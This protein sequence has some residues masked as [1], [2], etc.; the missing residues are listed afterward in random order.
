MAV[1]PQ[2]IRNI[3]L[4]GHGGAGKTTLGEA[5]LHQAKV[6]TRLGSTDEG[7]SLLD[8]SAIEKDRQHS[9][10]PSMANFEHAGAHINLIDAPGYPDFIGGSI[11]ALTGADVAVVVV[12]ATAG[13]EVNT[14]RLFKIAQDNKRALA[15]VINKMDGEN[16]DLERVLAS[17]Q[18]TFGAACRPMT[19]PVN[20]RAGVVNCFTATEGDSDLGPV[21]DFR[22]QIVENVVEADESLMEAYL[23]GEEPSGEQ[24]AAAV[25]KAMIGG[26][27]IPVFFTAARQCIGAQELM[28]A[29]AKLFPSP[30]QMPLIAVRTGKAEDA[31]A[32]EI[33][34]DPD[35]PFVGQAVKITTDPFVGKLAWIRIFQ[36]RVAGETM[37]ILRDERKAAK[38]GHLFR[39]QGKDTQE[40]KEALAGDIIALAKV[41]DIQYG[42]VLHAEGD[43]MYAPTPYRPNPM[44]SLAVTPKS[45]GDEQKISEALHKLTQEDITFVAS[46]DNQTGETVIS[47]IG[48]LHLRIMLTKMQERFDLEVETK[49]PKIPYRE[50]ISTKADGHYRHK[51]QTG[52]AGQFG[53][54]YLRVEPLE[55]GS[56]YE[57][58]SELFGESIPRQFLPAIEKGVQDVWHQGAVA[59]YPMQDIKIAITDGKHHPV[60]SKEVA[61][62][63]AGKYAFIDAIEKAKPV[64]L[65]P[66]VDMEITVPANHMG[67]IASD[68]SGRRGRIM[69]QDMLPGNMVVVKAQAPLAEV[70]QYNSQLR[71]V[72]GGQGSYSMEFSHYEPVPGN[73][74]AQ[75]V[76]AGK[77]HAKD[78][79]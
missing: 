62:R 55:R 74:Q 8:Y 1:K 70:M 75:I 77:K 24:L 64:I 13:I 67:D 33:A 6:T 51:K 20:N 47:G 32:V 39:V 7:T 14:R 22:T 34:V 71:S 3:V 10:D 26:T 23:G 36:G 50:T 79:E 54:V 69:G 38:V 31:E 11:A 18:E 46:R 44:Y 12:S 59:G 63:T 21:A 5:M 72:T 56:G 76:A 42:D 43:A 41:D 61:F 45:R 15:I 60:D 73:V 40:I 49:P 9:V 37:Y 28:D 48:D 65:E 16:A 29:A 66:I 58:V 17:V 30:L 25:S 53:E 68:L 57:F 4:L 19:L 52:G 27:L 35:K 2:D 78:E